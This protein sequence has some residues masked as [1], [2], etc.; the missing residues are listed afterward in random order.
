VDVGSGQRMA[1]SKKPKTIEDKTAEFQE[2]YEMYEMAMELYNRA[3]MQIT[4][5]VH[6][7]TLAPSWWEALKKDPRYTDLDKRALSLTVWSRPG[8]GSH[9]PVAQTEGSA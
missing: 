4:N 5:G 8:R 1:G 9:W 6:P 3:A 7:D 2:K